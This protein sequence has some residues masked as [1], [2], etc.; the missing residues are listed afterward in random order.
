[1]DI[2]EVKSLKVEKGS[3]LVLKSDTASPADLNRLAGWLDTELGF[4]P[5]VVLIGTDED[6]VTVKLEE[7]IVARIDRVEARLREIAG[8]S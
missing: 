1:M 4:R 3:V 2:E 5:L 7:S 8:R 6:F